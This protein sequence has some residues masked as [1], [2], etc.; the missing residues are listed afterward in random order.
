MKIGRYP[1]HHG[2][3]GAIRTLGRLGIP[4]Y[5]I[6]EDSLTPAALSRYCRQAFVWPTTGAEDPETL[7]DG[8]LAIGARIGRPTVPVPT[9]E[10]AA[11]LL[12][13]HAGRLSE[14]FLLPAVPPGLP[15]R[16]A[17]KQGLYELCREHGV[18]APASAFPSSAGTSS[19]AGSDS[20]CS[21]A[22][23]TAAR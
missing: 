17:S 4:V 1:L 14:W 12:A 23:P 10:E 6:T 20:T 13:E 2:G 21:P 18:P 22:S 16:L 15:G 8:L 19:R 11:V 5:A 9:D 7:V 3:V